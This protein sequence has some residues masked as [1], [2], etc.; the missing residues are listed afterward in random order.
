MDE[1]NTAMANTT[2]D[3][4]RKACDAVTR[5]IEDLINA[6]RSNDYSPERNNIKPPIDYVFDL[7]KE[8]YAMEHTIVEAFD[9]Q[10]QTDVE[11]RLFVTPIT[12]AL[13][14][15]LPA[16][17]AYRLYFPIHPSKGI[18]TKRLAKVQAK[19]IEWVEASAAELYS[20]CLEQPTHQEKPRNRGGFREK[21]IEGVELLLY[22][23][24]GWE[25]PNEVQ[26][27][28]FPIRFA[29]QE[30]ENLRRERLK[31]TMSK[32]LPKLQSWKIDGAHSVLVL[33]N[34]DIAISSHVSI[35]EAAEHAL[36]GRADRPDEVWLVDTTIEM[37]WTVWCLIREGV[38][39]PDEYASIRFKRF[40]PREL[41][42]V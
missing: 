25:M 32:K 14:Y 19:I 4:E 35:L 29:P 5:V 38:S 12:D 40:S 36:E 24:I 27:R 10:I 37:Q 39:L 7:G 18:K 16:P 17:G 8:K 9:G 1:D 6:K 21:T 13:D 33:E 28:L 15:R 22:R 42:E 20:E 31:I 23:K 41:T 34:R 30:Y 26:G 2:G 3:N 11:F